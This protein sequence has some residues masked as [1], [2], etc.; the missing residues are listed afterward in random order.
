MAD[1]KQACDCPDCVGGTADPGRMLADLIE[2]AA[3]L[4][5]TEDPLDAE[6]AG[7]FFVAL[8]QSD[9]DASL[10]AFADAL[11]PAV[12]A[13]G[14]RAA[15]TLLAAISAVAGDEPGSVA[16]A[17]RA[18]AER[19]VGAGVAAPAWADRLAQ[20]L[21]AGPFTRMYDAE[22]TMSVL[23]GVFQRAGRGH[24]LVI[25]VD[26]ENC[27]AA[28]EI[29]LVGEDELPTLVAGIHQNARGDGV[30]IKTKTLNAPEFRWYAE[31]ALE[32]RADHD[33]EDGP[34]ESPEDLDLVDE[35]GPGYAPL[36]VLTR[37]RLATLPPARRP[38]GAVASPH[39]GNRI[40]LDVLQQFAALI[41]RS[42]G[43]GAPGPDLPSQ[44]RRQPAKL[45]AK[46][47]KSNGPAPA[48]QLKV[49]LR[50]A[51]PPIWRRLL[52]PGDITLNRLHHALLAAFG[53]H[54]GH[55]HVFDTDYGQ[56]G[57]ADRDLGHRSDGPVTL[58]QVAHGVTDKFR[59][60]YDFGDNWEH[61][62]LVEKVTPADPSL[63]YPLCTGGRRAAPPDDCGGIWGYQELIEILA[64][65]AHEEHRDRLE[66]LGLTDASRFNPATFDLE[67]VNQQLRSAR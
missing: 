16:A 14:T 30:T 34:A 37:S 8:A 33:A 7:A 28:D 43:L 2:D 29:Y 64:D 41:G 45:P 48:Y 57:R 31:Q 67:Q 26:H 44:R 25:V 52:V 50:G 11:V 4:A 12:E 47:K 56:F 66:W 40:P 60:T 61:E 58:E 63:E 10:T 24:A 35:D 9:G 22:D 20:P 32:I 36:A 42:G 21:T 18:A 6:L 13:R 46:R 15:L 19:L 1:E 55:L 54:G 49:S 17:A 65:P 27:G 53:W 38:R 39:A 3:T 51:K 23:I 62:I 59:Y 5:E